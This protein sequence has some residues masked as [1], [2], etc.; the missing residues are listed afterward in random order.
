MLHLK[1][2]STD[3]TAKDIHDRLLAEKPEGAVHDE[4]ECAYCT[5]EESTP[6]EEKVS[7]AIFTQE[8]HEQLL[9]SAIE[10]ATAEATNSSDAELLTVN[11][12]LESVK[13]DL[14]ARDERITELEQE[15]AARD[16]KERLASLETER[17]EQVKAVASFTDEQIEARKEKWAAM[18]DEAFASLLE[19]FKAVS[20]PA[21]TSE[22]ARE[23]SNFNGT[24]ET[25]GD[26][27]PTTIL[28]S[29]FKTGLVAAERL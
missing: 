10:K 15:I 9:A 26:D 7:E 14:A 11:Q 2:M 24:R 16:E 22:K 18:E 4:A 8:Q 21:S 25:T 13:A 17:V 12:E 5:T 3:M 27:E 20:K 23:T 28:E 6:Q 19:D 1:V 29:F